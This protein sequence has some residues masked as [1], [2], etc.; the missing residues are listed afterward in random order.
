MKIFIVALGSLGDNVPLVN[1]GVELQKRGCDVT[2]LGCDW[3]KELICKA[4]LDFYSI[5]SAEEAEKVSNNPDLWNRDKSFEVMA[6]HVYGPTTWRV[7]DFIKEQYK[8]G[9][10]I[11]I[12]SLFIF[13]ARFAHELLEIP[14]ATMRI[15]PFALWNVDK[16]QEDIFNYTLKSLLK[17]ICSTKNVS[18]DLNNPY[19]WLYSPQKIIGLFPE[20]FAPKQ[21]NWPAHIQLTDFPML[22]TAQVDEASKDLIEFLDAGALP[23]IF[24]PGTGMRQSASFFQESLNVCLDLGIR[25][26]FLTP[27]KDQIPNSLPQTIKHYKYLPLAGLLPRTS[28]IV[29]HGGIGTCA[30]ALKAGVPH[31][32]MPMAFD[33]FDNAARLKRL[34]VGDAV[35][36]NEYNRKTVSEKAM[37]LLNSIKVKNSCAEIKEKFSDSDGVSATCD[38]IINSLK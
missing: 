15:S 7:F 6:N 34:G 19:Q 16:K 18:Y 38:A 31:L 22:R 11:I 26:I 9:N 2:V 36:K 13:G 8:P 12:A 3:F 1:I 24:T 20:W 14:L 33:Q 30:Q 21:S 32:V 17:G 27:Y 10:S 23:V 35:D 28:C 37:K 5:L 25:G 4:G 29:Y